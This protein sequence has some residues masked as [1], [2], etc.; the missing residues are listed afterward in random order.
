M[1]PGS[2]LSTEDLLCLAMEQMRLDTKV[3][4]AERGTHT[5]NPDLRRRFNDVPQQPGCNKRL[6]PH[7]ALLRNR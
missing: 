1:P 6:K 5:A 2:D 3:N 4:S 7:E